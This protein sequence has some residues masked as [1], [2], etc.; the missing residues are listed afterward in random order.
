VRRE[1]VSYV[2]QRPAAN[3]VPHLTLAEQGGEADELHAAFGVA[4]RLHALPAELSGGEQARAAFA[5]ALARDTPIVVADEPTAE[6]DRDSARLLL[7][8]VRTCRNT[9]FI[10]ATH[11][12]D[13]V[14]AADR[15]LRLERG[16][17]ITGEQPAVTALDVRA[18]VPGGAVVRARAVAKSYRRG[19][20]TV[21]ALRSASVELARGEVGA[22]LGR[23]GSGKSTLLTLLGGW[24]RPDAGEIQY[25]S[26]PET[27]QRR[28]W[29]QLAILP[30]RFGLLPELTVR[31]NVELPVRLTDSP[32]SPDRV[33]VVLERFGLTELADRL[34]AE[35]S[36]G[37]Q[38]RIALARALVLGPEVLLADEP[39]SHQDAGWR[40][41]VWKL[42]HDTAAGDGTACLV[43]T[44]E[45]RVAGYAN[46]VWTIDEGITRPASIDAPHDGASEQP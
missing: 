39:T 18:P 38:Q 8:V 27:P 28:R 10:L 29:R 17:V 43:A 45:Q 15:V 26:G 3:F 32:L 33:D 24:Q 35:T 19:G 36:I 7:D 30:Q 1:V 31:E 21:Q 11:D 34:P 4:H 40:D 46:R 42:I 9:A 14:A 23:S 16:K 12:S 44:H 20:Q 22:V 37:Q 6:L 13:V 5:L 41:A 25:A 2:F